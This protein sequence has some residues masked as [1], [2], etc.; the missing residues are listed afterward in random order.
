LLAFFRPVVDTLGTQL[1]LE[2]L[3]STWGVAVGDNVVVDPKFS[4]SVSGNEFVVR[5]VGTHPLLRPL[6]QSRGLD[7]V[8]PRSVG[9]MPAGPS[10]ADAPQVEILATT[11]PEGRVITD[12]RKGAVTPR[13][14]D[15]IGSIPLMVAVEKGNLR[16]VSADRGSTRMVVVGESIFLG[17]ET[18]DKLANREFASHALNWLLARQEL[19][20][21]IPA[22]PIRDFKV[23]ISDSQLSAVRWILMLGMPGGVVLMGLLV[24]V[25]RRK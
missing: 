14:D 19:L 11:S 2:R 4:T 15:V 20:L 9:K 17:N 6:Y 21:S 12:I 3:L 8:L 25:R 22:R 23:T 13:P 7:V 10:A 1:G 5:H 18:I 24:S 16:N